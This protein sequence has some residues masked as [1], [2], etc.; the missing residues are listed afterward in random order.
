MEA[1][2]APE[3]NLLSEV[4]VDVDVSDSGMDLVGEFKTGFGGTC[5]D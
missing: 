5:R 2:L 3:M 4:I 1:I